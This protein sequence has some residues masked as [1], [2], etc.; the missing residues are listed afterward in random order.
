MIIQ[1]MLNTLD[2]VT[3]RLSPRTYDFGGQY[4]NTKQLGRSDIIFCL[5]PLSG[6]N[7]RDE[8]IQ[9]EDF[10]KYVLIRHTHYNSSPLPKGTLL[11][12]K[13]EDVA[14]ILTLV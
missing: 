12:K 1:C 9:Y 14:L 11:I 13:C 6:P 2:L 5:S 10:I 8:L 3:N 4:P 7:R